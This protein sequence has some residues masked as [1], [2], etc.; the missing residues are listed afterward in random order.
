MLL[1]AEKQ[2]TL[3]IESSEEEDEFDDSRKEPTAE[4]KD[5]DY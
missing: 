2:E 5:N 3:S 4:K 1:N